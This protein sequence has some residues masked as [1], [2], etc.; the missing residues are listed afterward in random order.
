M[1]IVH[2]WLPKFS[3][4]KLTNVGHAALSV[5]RVT[6]NRYVSWWPSGDGASKEQPGTQGHATPPYEEDILAENGDPSMSVALDCLMEPTIAHWWDRVAVSGFAIPFNFSHNPSST[7]YHLWENNCSTIVY[8]AMKV[9]GA[10]QLCPFPGTGVVTPPH[11][12]AWAQAV[13]TAASV[14]NAGGKLKSA[15]ESAA[16]FI[17][18]RF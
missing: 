5:D 15:A 4:A 3:G 14:K 7:N 11:I 6:P 16:R 10:E 18:S 8:L 12:L 17:K 13:K 9:G 1:A 2:V